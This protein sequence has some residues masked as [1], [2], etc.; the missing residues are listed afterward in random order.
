M[1]A[2]SSKAGRAWPRIRSR[3]WWQPESGWPSTPS[4]SP[5][6]WMERGDRRGGDSMADPK[7]DRSDREPPALDPLR[8]AAA[9]QPQ[10][11]AARRR[12]GWGLY[13]AGNTQ[14]GLAVFRLARRDFPEDVDVLYGLGLT[15]KRAGVVDEADEAFLLVASLAEAMTDPCRG[16]ILQ[17]LAT[18]HHNQVRTGRW[19]LKP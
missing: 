11:V 6:C 9:R 7:V 12:L 2:P 10:D 18:G 8:D 4:R 5:T 13:G 15:A 1:P 14:E 16:E 19:G 17:R 3:R